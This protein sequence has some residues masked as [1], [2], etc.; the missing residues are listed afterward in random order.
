MQAASELA[1]ATRP[2]SAS[3][4]PHDLTD[5]NLTAAWNK[6]P[7]AP[8]TVLDETG[9]RAAGYSGRSPIW[10]TPD[11]TRNL[12]MTYGAGHTGLFTSTDKTLRNWKVAQHMFYP[13]R[14]AGGAM[15]LPLPGPPKTQRDAAPHLPA[16]GDSAPARKIPY[17]HVIF[18]ISPGLGQGVTALG[19]YNWSAQTFSNSTGPP[20]TAGLLPLPSRDDGEDQLGAGGCVACGQTPEGDRVCCADLNRGYV[21]FRLNFHHFDRFELDL[22]GHVH[23][24]GAAFSCL[25]LKLADIVLI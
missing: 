9:G 11:G 10:T 1:S 20:P 17:T 22:R 12:I 23:V 4:A 7:T 6:D 2:F 8:I 5:P 14:D 25:R 3:P 15:F 16:E 21:T 24:Q 19:V 18:G 13:D